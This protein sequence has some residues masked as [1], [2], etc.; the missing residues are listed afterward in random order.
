MSMS[1]ESTSGYEQKPVEPPI[2]AK[3]GVK[4]LVWMG[5][6]LSVTS[7]AETAEAKPRTTHENHGIVP[8]KYEGKMRELPRPDDLDIEK[9]WRKELPDGKIASVYEGTYLLPADDVAEERV[10]DVHVFDGGDVEAEGDERWAE[11]QVIVK[12]YVDKN[13]SKDYGYLCLDSASDAR[14][15]GIH[16]D[17]PIGDF[18]SFGPGDVE[19]TKQGAA[20]KTEEDWTLYELNNLYWAMKGLKEAGVD[21]ESEAARYLSK[22]FRAKIGEAQSHEKK[23]PINEGVLEELK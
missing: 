14:A 9:S 17:S 21:Q 16:M 13:R 8:F 7:M 5:A 10:L 15:S 2:R 4:A 11:C 22:Q 12:T 3:A 6:L 18:D 19:W 1:F 20:P 23:K